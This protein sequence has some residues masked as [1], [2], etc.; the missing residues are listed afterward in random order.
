MGHFLCGRA[1]RWGAVRGSLA[2]GI[3]SFLPLKQPPAY[4]H[5]L[6]ESCAGECL[7]SSLLT[8]KIADFCS[9]SL[10][11]CFRPRAK[12]LHSPRDCTFMVSYRLSINGRQWQSACSCSQPRSRCQ[13]TPGSKIPANPWFGSH[14]PACDLPVRPT[15]SQ[16]T[17][18]LE[19]SS[20]SLPTFPRALCSPAF[21]ACTGI[22]QRCVGRRDG[23]WDI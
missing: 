20:S 23:T 2:Q 3:S 22:L 6:P 8:V 1:S 13:H 14:S 11:T 21:K 17:A 12:Q 9:F 4:L 7:E 18:W 19:F 15:H 16:A 5:I 10:F